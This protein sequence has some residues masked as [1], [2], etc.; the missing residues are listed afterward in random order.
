MAKSL[1]LQALTV[2]A[3]DKGRL[4][5]IITDISVCAAFDPASPP[6][7]LPP[8]INAKTLWDTGATNSVISVEL[9]KSLA[10][11]SVGISNVTHGGGKGTSPRYAVNFQLP[12]GVGIIGVLVTEFPEPEDKSFNVIVGMDV[13]CIGDLSIT[14]V[15]GHTWMSFRTPSHE[16]IDYV[17]QVNRLQYAGVGPNEPCPCGSGKKFKKCHRP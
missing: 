17:A 15:G 5:R 12:N 9:A 1:S 13:I 8:A 2:K 7:Q 11:T 6:N 4:N 16:A 14:N 3:V 10:L